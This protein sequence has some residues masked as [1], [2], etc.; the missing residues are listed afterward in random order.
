MKRGQWQREWNQA[1]YLFWL[2]KETECILSITTTAILNSRSSTTA[3]MHLLSVRYG[4]SIWSFALLTKRPNDRWT[5]QN[6]HH[7]GCTQ[8]NQAEADT[9]MKN[10]EGIKNDSSS[11]IK[12]KCSLIVTTA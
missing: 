7:H 11:T 12:V 4:G 10:S 5:D 3:V 8:F 6:D 1:I 9:E 2:L